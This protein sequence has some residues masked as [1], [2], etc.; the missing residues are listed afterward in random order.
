M[1][2][3][4]FSWLAVVLSFVVAM[5]LESVSLPAVV[6]FLRPEWVM[7]TLVYWL[8]RHPEKVGIATA[9][10]AGLVMDVIS[11]TYFGIHVLSLSLISYLVLLTHQRLKMYP[12]AQQ[13]LTVFLITGIHLMVVY[14]M[15]SLLS[16]AD[17]G[18]D[19]LW[20]ALTSALFWPLVLIL[21]DRLVYALR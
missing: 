10:I 11:G 9:V 3:Y 21:Y 8:L 1:A 17:G 5:I 16:Y 2:A 7:L 13:S 12:V 18:L 6:A 14:T 4:R 15:R 19:Y 20:Q